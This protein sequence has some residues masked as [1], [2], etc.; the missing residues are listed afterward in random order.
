VK[1]TQRAVPEAMTAAAAGAAILLALIVPVV[2]AACGATHHQSAAP[3]GSVRAEPT[4]GVLTGT[5]FDGSGFGQVEPKKVYNGGDPTGLVISIVWHTWGGA[6]AVGTGRGVYV[7]PN[8]VVAA[9]TVEPVR[10]VAFD[11]GTC[12]GRYMYEAVEWYFPQHGQAF[13]PSQFEDVCIGAYYPP[14]TGQYQDGGSDGGA[15]VAHYLLTLFGAPGSL[16]GSI[17]Q[18]AAGGQASQPLFS[19]RGRAGLDGSLA[20]VSSGPFEPG[21]TFTGT[22]QTL[23]AILGNCRSYLKSAATPEPS[24]TFYW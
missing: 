17:S 21:R 6:Q 7:G 20:L 9:G 5:F 2:L 3:A 23:R 19:F 1:L 8:Q 16:R 24:C 12:H 4:L 14:Q 18:I 13:N 10:I 15:G 22:W 11:L